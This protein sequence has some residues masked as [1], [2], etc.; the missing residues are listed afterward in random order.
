[1]AEKVSSLGRATGPGK[2][3]LRRRERDEDAVIY[4][5]LPGMDGTGDYF[6]ALVRSAPGG[7][8]PWVIRYPVGEVLDYSGYVDL[9]A[10]SLPSEPFVLVGESF[11]GP[12]AIRLAGRRPAGLRAVILC[13]TFATN[14]YWRAF[15]FLPWE[16]LLGLPAPGLALGYFLCGF[17]GMSRFAASIRRTNRKVSARVRASRVR[18]ALAVDVR[19]LLRELPYPILYL[20]GSRDRLIRERSLRQL[21]E[22]RPDTEVRRFD[23]PH[24]LL[25]FE[26]ERCWAAMEEFVAARGG[27]D[28]REGGVR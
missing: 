24:L 7:V 13:N 26:P 3:G 2:D 8:E 10:R 9:V 4:L 14:P 21:R 28:G 22:T 12:V 11:S 1:M 20:R 5:L 25:Q 18:E 27:V 19:S 17:S 16:L 15:R 23:A 6:A